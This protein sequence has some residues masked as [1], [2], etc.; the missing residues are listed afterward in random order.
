MDVAVRRQDA[1]RLA[2]D[3]APRVVDDRG[4]RD[5]HGR[6]RSH[7][8]YVGPVANHTFKNF[9]LSAEVM[10]TPGSNSGI[11]VHTALQG[12]GFPAAGYEL[13]VINSTRPVTGNAYVER[14]MTGSIY[15]IRNNW[16]APV[17]DNQWFTYRIRVVGK[18]IQ[19]FINDALVCEYTEPSEPVAPRRQEGAPARIGHVRAAGP[20]S[21]QRRALPRVARARAARRS[22]DARHRARR[23]RARRA[24][25]GACR[26]T[27]SR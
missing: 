12:P 10:T 17:P 3:R 8:F 22:A 1:D 20:R 2:G 14:K 24:D 11:Y 23:P 26:T 7:L 21:R 9:E 16:R 25:H 27:T 18:T 6:R 15:A 13:Q 5:R 19:T 4:R